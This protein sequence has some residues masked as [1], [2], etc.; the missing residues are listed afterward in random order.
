[1]K[2]ADKV[3]LVAGGVQG[4]NERFVKCMAKE[5]ANVSI[6]DIK[7]GS[8]RRIAVEIKAMGRKALALTAY[9]TIDW[10]RGAEGRMERVREAKYQ[11][12]L[13]ARIAADDVNKIT[14]YEFWKK[15][16]VI[17]NTPLGREQT[18][19]DIGRAT[20][21]LVSEN[22]KNITGQILHVNGKQVMQ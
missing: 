4:I 7:G 20:V 13:L 8:A 21:F 12:P 2:L 1:M 11:N 17:P 18:P 9:L 3:V 15:Y 16:I 5:G 10:V 22:A 14:P 19:E 6:V